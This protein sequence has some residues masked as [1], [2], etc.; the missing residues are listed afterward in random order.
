[1]SLLKG[2]SENPAPP[3][4]MYTV[5]C[6]DPSRH[7]YRVSLA[8]SGLA[9]GPHR[10]TLPVWAGGYEIENFSRH[11]FDLAVRDPKGEPV[12]VDKASK[13]TW[14]FD[15]ACDTATVTYAVYAFDLGTT[16][17]HLD[18]THAYWNGGTLFFYLD[19]D[20]DRPVAVRILAPPGWYASTALSPDPD[21]PMRFHAA[22]YDELV[23]SPVEV[24]THRRFTFTV[25]GKRHTIA[26]WG[27]GNQDDARLVRDTR[28]IVEAEASLFG[29]LPYPYYTFIFH[30]TERSTGG[31]EHKNSTTC[32]FERF[33]FQPQARY[34]R[35]LSLIAHEF[36]HLWNVKRIHPDMLGPFDYTQE[37]HTH[38]LWAMEGFT[39]Y[40]A[41][42]LLR[43]SGLYSVADYLELL[44]DDIKRYES[45]PGRFV[46]DLA[47]SS[48]DTWLRE[49]HPNADAPN[50]AMS[51]YLKGSL[52]G[53]V[54]DLEIRRGTRGEK[55]LDDVLRL[56]FER[57]GQF[58]Q[59][60]PERV[61]QET[62]EEVAGGS[63]AQ[64]FGRYINGVDP[65]PLDALLATAG[66]SLTRRTTA[67]GEGKNGDA[68]PHA[69][70]GVSTRME[71]GRPVVRTAYDPGPAAGVLDAG[72]ALVALNGIRIPD[73]DA[74][75]ERVAANHHPGDRVELC[76]F[77]RDR[78][79]TRTLELGTAPPNQYRVQRVARP[80][81]GERA[82]YEG[83]LGSEWPRDDA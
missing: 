16:R 39:S 53:L 77:R 24:G 19:D 79:I 34:R 38:L 1:M 15:A 80:T 30:I 23:D 70:L 65:L 8:L 13:S 60:F 26:L 55:S 54:L 49:Y 31:L 66:L 50:R 29:S 33:T 71:Q 81:A 41:A 28:R 7:V 59:G 57:Y 2:L 58:D 61:Y 25:A 72:D 52:V 27:E 43:R 3:S 22:N 18:D 48:F 4:L 44:A 10:L 47:R 42:L 35:A 83:W 12:P 62:A 64:F 37:V 78:L 17:S 40:Y 9:P 63:L 46:T 20:K 68:A 73:A 45:Q 51:Y 14:V 11:V 21:G 76:V 82:T 74:L 75:S 32:G 5:D 6:T 56:L 67:P 69:W 36:F